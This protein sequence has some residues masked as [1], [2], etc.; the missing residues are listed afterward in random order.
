MNLSWSYRIMFLYLGFVGIIV[1]LVTI[2]SRNKEELVS[3]DYYAQELLYQDK[4]NAINNEKALRES[5]SHQ[6]S[7]SSV[8]FALPLEFI[9]KINGDIS[10]YCPAD[11]KKDVSFKM[12]FGK[13][14]QQIISKTELKKGIYKLRLSWN[15]S[16][17]QY[18]KEDVI[19]IN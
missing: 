11:S 5:I 16:G 8:I 2:S 4:I 10:F 15:V 6:V 18:F 1:T 17:K 13:E 19:T 7:E 9:G 3:K 12:L 14:G